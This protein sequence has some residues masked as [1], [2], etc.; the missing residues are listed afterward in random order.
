MYF[1]E[2]LCISIYFYLFQKFPSISIHFNIFKPNNLIIK[3]LSIF[4]NIS[5]NF[6]IINM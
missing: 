5:F 2:F 3:Y 1:N 4:L 6:L